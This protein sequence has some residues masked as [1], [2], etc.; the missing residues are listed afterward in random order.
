[1][2]NYFSNFLLTSELDNPK[3]FAKVHQNIYELEK[4]RIALFN[5]KGPLNWEYIAIMGELNMAYMEAK[6]TSNEVST[7]QQIYRGTVAL[8]GKDDSLSY[9]AFL[10]LGSSLVDDDRLSEAQVIATELLELTTETKLPEVEKD[11]D[12]LTYLD[13]LCLQAD[14]YHKKE[15]FAKEEEIR[16][17]VLDAYEDSFGASND[18][19]VMARAALAICLEK[20]KRYSQALEQYIQIRTYLDVEKELATD[21]ERIGLLAH[22]AYCY[23]KIGHFEDSTVVLQWALNESMRLFGSEASLTAKMKT[24]MVK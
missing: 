20:L 1:M 22:I 2:E 11:F 21:A 7:A 9:E 8:N 4:Q 17:K 24:L 19:T 23:R 14:I 16:L 12:Y 6:D 3:F 13:A 15:T 5:K 10:A 18:Q